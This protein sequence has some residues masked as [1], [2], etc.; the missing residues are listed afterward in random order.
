ME[1]KQI[2][3]LERLLEEY[4]TLVSATGATPSVNSD[5][6]AKLNEEKEVLAKEVAQLTQTVKNLKGQLEEAQS[7]VRTNTNLPSPFA[8]FLIIHGF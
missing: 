2:I 6:I 5:D 8:P 4:R 1:A 3:E 7:K